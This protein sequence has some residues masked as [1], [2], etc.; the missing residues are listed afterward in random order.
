MIDSLLILKSL[1]AGMALG[2]IFFILKL[3]APAPATLSGV[4][5]VFGV[6]AGYLVAQKFL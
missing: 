2:G 1:L 4:V 3:P 6:F 5:G